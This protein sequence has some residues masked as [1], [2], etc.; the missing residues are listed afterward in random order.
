FQGN[1]Q[2]NLPFGGTP[3]TSG[4]QA[5]AQLAATATGFMPGVG[6]A[7]NLAAPVVGGDLRAAAEGSPEP[8]MEGAPPGALGGVAQ[9]AMGAGRMVA[10][11]VASSVGPKLTEALTSQRA[12]DWI[13]ALV[14]D[15]PWLKELAGD[16]PQ[17]GDVANIRQRGQALLSGKFQAMDDTLRSE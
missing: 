13:K 6:L 10:N 14:K 7:A 8:M 5:G 4:A 9:G 17:V 2:T 3:P 15:A 12:P 16:A 1:V 11:K